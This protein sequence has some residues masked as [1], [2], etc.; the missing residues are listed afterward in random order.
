M[1]TDLADGLPVVEGET[2]GD[3]FFECEIADEDRAREE[4][5]CGWSGGRE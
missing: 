1:R 4:G 2:D 5:L 3:M